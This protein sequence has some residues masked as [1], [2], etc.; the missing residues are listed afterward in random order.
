VKEA[1]RVTN[2]LAE[3]FHLILY[4]TN[5][6]EAI[7]RTTKATYK[8]PDFKTTRFGRKTGAD[9]NYLPFYFVV[10]HFFMGFCVTNR[11][12]PGTSVGPTTPKKIIPKT[13]P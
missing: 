1:L 8:I 5:N 4:L 2:V 10:F 12:L 7:T 6:F 13:L 3:K 9:E 11:C